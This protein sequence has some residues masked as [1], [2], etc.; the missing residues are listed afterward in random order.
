MAET[1]TQEAP[2]GSWLKNGDI[3]LSLGVVG[4]LMLMILP[5]P[6]VLVDLLLAFNLS[7]A[8]IVL[9]VSMYTLHPMEFSAFPS[10]LLLVTLF[11]LALNI[12]STRLILL[13][14]SEGIDAAG[15]VIE[16][17]GNFVVGGNYTVGL[18]VFAILVVINFV[19]ITKGAGRIAEVAARFTLDAMPGKQMAIDADLNAG[20][21]DEDEARRSRRKAVSQEADF[22]GAMDGASKF[23]RGD[24]IAGIVIIFVN[25]LGG[26]I[27]GVLQQGMGFMASDS[28]CTPS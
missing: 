26:L 17:F 14:G 18:V 16:T 20:L 27:I 4:I 12:A 7:L 13:H 5:L 9:F 21:I 11:R 15:Q 22:Y 19:V 3:V 23:V 6:R 24:A 1:V 25:I 2:A 10:V 28:T 8:L